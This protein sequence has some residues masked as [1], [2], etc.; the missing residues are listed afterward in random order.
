ML[1]TITSFTECTEFYLRPCL[2]YGLTQDF[3]CSTKSKVQ[4]SVIKHLTWS[5]QHLCKEIQWLNCR[6]W[7]GPG[8]TMIE[9]FRWITSGRGAAVMHVACVVMASLEHETLSPTSWAP[10]SLAPGTRQWVVTLIELSQYQVS[11]CVQLVTP[12]HSSVVES[13]K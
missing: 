10:C 12:E 4:I 3:I 8:I 5:E 13:R 2:G 6:G 11:V 7:F 9:P 1:I